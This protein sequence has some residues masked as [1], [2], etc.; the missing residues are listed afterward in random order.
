MYQ[1]QRVIIFTHVGQRIVVLL[2][3]EG[4]YYGY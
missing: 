1:K 2:L 4:N 3:L